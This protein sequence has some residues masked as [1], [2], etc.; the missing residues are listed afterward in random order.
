MSWILTAS[1]R[2]FDYLDPRPEDIDILDIAQGLAN[3][4]RYAGHTR[5]FYSVAQHAWLASRIVPREYAFEA[6][7]HD[8]AE[9]Y[10]KDIPRPLK[11][12]LPDYR[13]IEARVDIAIRARFGLPASMSDTVKQADLVLLATERRD[14]MPAD[15]SPWSLL[16]G[17][18]PLARR[19]TAMPP[20][21]AQ[22]LFLK[23]WIELRGQ[24]VADF[25]GYWHRISGGVRTDGLYRIDQMREIARLAFAAGAEEK[26]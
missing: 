24:R 5:C 25:D 7:L 11:D 15:G 26:L 8:A 20:A 21:K 13:D 10:V 9:A 4:C 19:I 14:L 16:E 23:R 17:I 12:L 22:A 3:E 2:H 18:T 1:G 6:L